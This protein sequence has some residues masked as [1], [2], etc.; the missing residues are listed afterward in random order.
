MAKEKGIYFKIKEPKWKWER[1]GGLKKVKEILDKTIS[2]PLRQNEKSRPPPGVL[3]WGPPGG[4][5]TVLAEAAAH[6]A[7]SNYIAT[8]AIEILSE[9]EEIRK[10]YDTAIDLAPCIVFINE[11]DAL[12]PERKAKSLFT[13]GITRDAPFRVAPSDATNIFYEQLDRV[14]GKR[15]VVTIGGTYRLDVLDRKAGKKGRLEKKIY[16]PPPNYEDRLDI[17]RIHLKGVH[18]GDISVEEL[19]E[20]TEYYVGADIRGVVRE[21]KL[22][23]IKEKGT[24]E[25]IEKKHFEEALRRVPPYLSPE[26][27]KKYETLSRTYSKCYVNH[28]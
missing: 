3:L 7:K 4:G 15:D 22:I 24:F 21:A 2:V 6:S 16:V 14:S 9:P 10:M 18:L 25:K 11:V 12:V 27:L 5:K 28:I 23:A 1:I 26:T 8:K 20:K 17:F 19:A 13:L